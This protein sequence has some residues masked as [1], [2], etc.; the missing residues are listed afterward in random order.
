VDG[1]LKAIP[2][3]SLYAQTIQDVIKWQD[4]YRPAQNLATGSGEV[5][6]CPDGYKKPFNIDA[7]L[8]GA[9]IFFSL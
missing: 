7:E 5:D 4:Q 2:A 3:Q 8:N 9:Y 6:H 1:G